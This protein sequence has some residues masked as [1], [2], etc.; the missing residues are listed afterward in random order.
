[1]LCTRAVQRLRPIIAEK[2]LYLAA[3][4]TSIFY[5]SAKF[6]SIRLLTKTGEKEPRS[7]G[8]LN[9]EFPDYMYLS[10]PRHSEEFPLLEVSSTRMCITG[11]FSAP[12]H[13]AKY[14]ED[15]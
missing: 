15:L 8:E 5:C 7:N 10:Q 9:I 12:E 6:I 1:M 4:K 2:Y 13:M 3:R 11:V 14:G